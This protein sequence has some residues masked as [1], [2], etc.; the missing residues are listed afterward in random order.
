[1]ISDE[2]LVTKRFPRSSRYHPEWAIAAASGGANSLWLM[3]WLAE[4]MALRTGM[5]VLD[6]GC[7]RGASSIF[8][9]REFGIE[10]WATDLW[11]SATERLERIRDAGV[12]DGVFPISAD[13]R[14]LPFATGF[15]DAIVSID[16]FPYW[17]TDDLY[18]SYITRF[19]KPGGQIGIAGAGLAR[20]IEG[21]V[22]EPL[23]QWWEPS[24]SC[25]HSA[26]WWSQHWERSAV[27]DVELADTMP[28]GWQLWLDWQRATSPD[29]RVEIHAVEAD[30]GRSLAYVR[31]VA[32]RQAHAKL[33]EEDVPSSVELRWRPCQAA[34]SSSSHSGVTAPST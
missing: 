16:A 22:P 33:D 1:M 29:N 8:L 31:V 12:E 3:E 20:E 14:S 28:D 23:R 7:G 24:M 32:R 27:L 5:R 21:P 9:H 26:A 13:A 18:A 30:G 2:R 10:V 11:F 34:T 19:L 4:A 15:F 25:L 17:G 6:L